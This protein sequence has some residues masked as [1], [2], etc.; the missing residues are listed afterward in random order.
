MDLP[1]LLSFAAAFLVI[2]ASPGPDNMTI[3]ARTLTHGA[4]SGIAYGVGHDGAALCGS[5]LADLDGR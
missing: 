2:A 5:G 4:A 1:T 3:I